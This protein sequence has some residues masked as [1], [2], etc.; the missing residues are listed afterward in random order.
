[1]PGIAL[2]IKIG[3]KKIALLVLGLAIVL[4]LNAFM[5]KKPEVLTRY[6]LALLMEELLGANEIGGPVESIPVFKDLSE[7][8]YYPIVRVLALKI[9]V[10]FSDESFRPNK[11]VRNMEVMAGLQR[12]ATI[13]HQYKPRAKASMKLMRLFAYR[14]DPKE[15]LSTNYVGLPSSFKQASAFTVK[16]EAAVIFEALHNS[17]PLKSKNIEILVMDSQTQEPIPSAFILL[18][19]KK[20]MKADENGVVQF[21]LPSNLKQVEIFVTQ[22]GYEPLELR[23]DLSLE[24]K[25]TLLLNQNLS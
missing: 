22:E 23:K 13:F 24:K 12:L 3:F 7:D 5:D 15:A 21:V 8:K 14:L 1:M 20:I 16:E 17:E 25:V 6:E 4:F 18:N 19:S 10:G 9:M 2:N 11:P